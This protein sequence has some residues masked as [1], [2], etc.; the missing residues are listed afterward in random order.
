MATRTTPSN[1]DQ[2]SIS[3]ESEDAAS[4]EA[5]QQS[6]SSVEQQRRSWQQSWGRAER[7]S[8][9]EKLETLNNI[10]V[11]IALFDWAGNAVGTLSF[12]WATAVLLGGFC[13]LLSRKDFWFATVMVLMEGYRI[14]PR[15]YL[16]SDPIGQ[17]VFI[18]NDSSVNQ[19]LLGSTNAFRW[20]E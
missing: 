2:H 3:I 17:T 7:K 1:H 5:P 14:T 6:E 18:R 11:F 10:V 12:L 13:S 15:R 9:K 19:R 16:I 8:A 20:E 4:G